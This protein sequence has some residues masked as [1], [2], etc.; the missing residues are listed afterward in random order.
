[1]RRAWQQHLAPQCKWSSNRQWRCEQRWSGKPARSKS[2]S[3][4]LLASGARLES[5]FHA[6]SVPTAMC[7]TQTTRAIANPAPRT[8]TRHLWGVGTHLPASAK[9]ASTTTLGTVPTG[10]NDSTPYTFMTWN[11]KCLA[12]LAFGYGDEFP[13]FLTW[14]AGVDKKVLDLMRPAFDKGM[15]PDGLSSL[16]LEL[17]TKK[18]TR[19]YVS[20][21]YDLRRK[22]QLQ[23]N[24]RADM[25]SQFSDKSKFDGFRIDAP[26]RK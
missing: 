12:K 23:P 20:R 7:W 18:Y 19:S 16:L 25:F 8:R 9:E 17:H 14:R 26:C 1:M 13:A 11:Q 22:R 2:K 21:E 3:R 24:L 6:P 15:R 5:R 4:V 10:D